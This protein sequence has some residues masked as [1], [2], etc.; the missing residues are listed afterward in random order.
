MNKRKVDISIIIPVLNEAKSIEK[1]CTR[2]YEMGNYREILVVDGG[3]QDKTCQ[4]AAPYASIL[5]SPQGRAIQM[6]IG[7]QSAAGEILWFLHADCIPHPNSIDA[8]KNTIQNGNIVGGA[9]AYQLD[10]YGLIYRASESLSNYKNRIF[11]I[12][13]G[14]MGIFIRKK[15]FE[16][17]GGYQ[18]IP[19][20][21]D[22]DL[23]LRLKKRGDTIILPQQIITSARRWKAEGP[24]KNIFRNWLLQ[25]GW[26]TG[27]SP[28]WLAKYYHFDHKNH[29][30]NI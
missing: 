14:D 29:K 5:S 30:L 1:I 27:I 25:L 21:E 7:A 3:S 20:M 10:S 6:N 9:F 18:E 24:V 11:N 13:Y 2:I 12:F 8:I 28:D 4:I 23:C 22:I 15:V 26:I 19:V 17:M 16:M